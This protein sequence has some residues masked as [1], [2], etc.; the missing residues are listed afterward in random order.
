MTATHLEIGST[1]QGGKYEILQVLGQGGFGIT[2]LVRHTLLGTTQAIK[3]FF[4][5]DYCNR[6][7]QTSHITVA[8]V[9]NTDL[10][11]RLRDR[12][13]T[14]ARN[15]VKL[16]HPGI[17]QIHDVF[18][19][20]GTAYYV[21][22]FIEGESL[23]D[24]VDRLGALP[25]HQAIGYIR[26]VA[27]ALSF[28][29][30]HNM[31]HFD[32]KPANIMV[33][34]SDGTP[35]LIDFGLSKQFNEQGHARSTLLMGVSHGYSPI[36][37][38]Y[39]EGITGFSPQTDIYSLGA[40]LYYLLTS[41][42]PPAAPR[43]AGTVIQLP[44][45]VS[46]KVADAI[47]GAMA[48]EI[49]DRFES[50]EK[51]IEA[52]DAPEADSSRTVA[53]APVTGTYARGGSVASPPPPVP[54][55]GPETPSVADSDGTQDSGGRK[56]HKTLIGSLIGVAVILAGVVVYLISTGSKSKSPAESY[57][58]DELVAMVE[59]DVPEAEPAVE[60]AQEEDAAEEVEAEA[61]NDGQF[62]TF[63]INGN[64]DGYDIRMVITCDPEGEGT[65]HVHGKYAYESTIKKYG[66]GDSNWFYFDGYG[67]EDG[68]GISW[69]ETTPYNP[70]YTGHFSG[71]F[72]NGR[73]SG[74]LSSN[75]EGA[76]RCSIYAD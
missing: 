57:S 46:P 47:R 9:S 36:E 30:A 42:V 18:E 24:M 52:L 27:E 34:V 68:S 62:G 49:K 67:N 19:E 8:T 29:H 20:N 21:M 33:R 76:N 74:T 65:C 22:D 39:E 16:R 63:H 40:T 41:R 26:R 75:V 38:Y 71:S 31:T 60:V 56:S 55:K 10:V 17:I 14:E 51:F 2:Y 32:V 69:D 72:R 37:Q 45:T 59:E 64:V 48:T 23:D 3:E 61:V 73:L 58:D 44:L 43:L 66:S 13:I 6:D 28:I 35:V 50:A 25:E 7:G 53:V 4:P 1:L 54:D 12:F 15:I 70:D 11:S 5:Q